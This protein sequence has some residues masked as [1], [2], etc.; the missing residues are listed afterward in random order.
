MSLITEFELPRTRNP[1]GRGLLSAS[2]RSRGNRSGS[3]RISSKMTRAFRSATAAAK[4][5]SAALNT[6]HHLTNPVGVA[7]GEDGHGDWV[8]KRGTA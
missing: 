1:T 4:G 2:T 7:L 6:P 5:L 3:R 8:V